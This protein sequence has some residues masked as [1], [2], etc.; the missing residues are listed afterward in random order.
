MD[1]V[2]WV[3]LGIAALMSGAVRAQ[4]TAETLG[5]STTTPAIEAAEPQSGAF[6][7]TFTEQDPR[8]PIQ[9]QH[10]RHRIG[11]TDLQKYVLANESFE[12][13]VP[14]DYDPATPYGIL[15]W[16][17]AGDSGRIP[18]GWDAVV[19]QHKLIFIGANQSGNRRGVAVRFGLAMDGVHNLKQKYNIDDARIYVTGVSGGGKVASMLGVLY[20]DVFQGAV[21]I[22][23]VSYFHG[24]PLVEDPTRGW[25]PDY[26]RPPAATYEMAQQQTRFVLITGS[27]DMNHDSIVGTYQRGFLVDGFQH[28][29]L[30]DVPEMGHGLP[31]VEYMDKA[32]DTLDAPLPKL[33]DRNFEQARELSRTKKYDAALLRYKVA[34]LHG[35]G[36]VAAEARTQIDWISGR[37]AEQK[38]TRADAPAGAARPSATRPAPSDDD[39][40][41]S[42]LSMASNYE[43]SRLYPQARERAERVLKEYPSSAA[44]KD[45]QAMLTR[46]KGK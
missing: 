5:G 46:L 8:S 29:E 16:V 33:A 25:A 35:T 4:D 20:P 34:A 23:G 12:V 2:A 1:R 28:V 31:P 11:V 37:L 7:A 36:T 15:V 14:D 9:A 24:V 18:R 44:A 39:A 40:A 10:A 13:Y 26:V 17:N 21:P 32:I 30:Y 6:H 19:K 27:R 38:P 3:A 45:A 22:V 42:L 43:R 41:Q